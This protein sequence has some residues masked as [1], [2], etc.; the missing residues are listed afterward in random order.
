MV[1]YADLTVATGI[2]YNRLAVIRRSDDCC[3]LGYVD[4]GAG[5]GN[6]FDE[7]LMVARR[8]I[9]AGFIVTSSQLQRRSFLGHSTCGSSDSRSNCLLD[10]RNGI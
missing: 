8:P 3:S 10:V 2:T 7:V 1:N 4:A 6:L 5:T 9:G